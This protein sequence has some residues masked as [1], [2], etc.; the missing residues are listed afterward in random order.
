MFRA[1]LLCV[2]ASAHA[3]LGDYAEAAGAIGSAREDLKVADSEYLQVVTSLIESLICR[4]VATWSGAGRSPSR[5]ATGSSRYSGR[6]SRVSGP[7]SLAYADLLY[8]QD[9]HAGVLAELPLAT[10]WRDVA[11]PVE[12]LSRGQ[13]VMARRASSPAPPSRGWRNSTNGWA[14]CSRPATSVS[15]LTP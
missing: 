5:R 2:Q 13:L 6:R 1:S 14:V 9:R 3:L 11:T 12:L 8:E 10:V 15:M 7:L 4:R